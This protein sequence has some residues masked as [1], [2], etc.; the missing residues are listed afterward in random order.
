MVL[1]KYTGL[2]GGQRRC[3]AREGTQAEP[4]GKHNSPFLL[5]KPS[6]FDTKWMQNW[7]KFTEKATQHC[8]AGPAT[9]Q[10]W[11]IFAQKSSFWNAEFF[12]FFLVCAAG[13]Q[14]GRRPRSYWVAAALSAGTTCLSSTE[15]IILNTKS[16]VFDTWFTV[17]I[18]KPIVFDSK[19][20]ACS[21]SWCGARRCS[22]ANPRICNSSFWIQNPSFVMH[23]LSI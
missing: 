19:F 11:V 7:Y 22:G 1:W 23:V 12:C 13:G 6:F 5:Q 20:T 3:G 9:S 8:R 15:F 17:F 21:W 4:A 14:R 16:I 18:T 2:T 10:G